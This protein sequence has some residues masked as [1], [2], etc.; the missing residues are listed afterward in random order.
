MPPKTFTVG[1]AN[2]SHTKAT[3]TP[4]D[5]AVPIYEL[6]LSWFTKELFTKSTKQSIVMRSTTYTSSSTSNSSS[7]SSNPV[8]GACVLP[9]VSLSNPIQLCFGDP[10]SKTAVW[11]SIF[12]REKLI[13]N[14]FELS[15]DLGGT[16]GRRTFDWK[17]THAVEGMGAMKRELDF[18]HLKMVE[19]ETGR[20]LAR[21]K[22]HLWYGQKRGLLEIEEYEGGEGWEFVVILSGMAVL[23]YLRKLSGYSF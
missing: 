6:D 21:F 2:K 13:C 18:L 16:L 15:I 1:L 7:A 19:R 14:G 17:R 5:S 11:E 10:N 22:H 3:I 9:F 23:E 12:C 20:V 8:L 4:T